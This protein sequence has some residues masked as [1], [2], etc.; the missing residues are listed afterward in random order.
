MSEIN[1]L[2]EQKKMI[3]AHANKIQSTH[4]PDLLWRV[5]KLWGMGETLLYDLIIEIK[6]ANFLLT[7]PLAVLHMQIMERAQHIFMA[8]PMVHPVH[9]VYLGNWRP[10]ALRNGPS[11]P[12]DQFCQ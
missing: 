10:M 12:C 1:Y 9:R 5:F 3:L 2:T 6:K 7:I 8:D 11:L 4:I